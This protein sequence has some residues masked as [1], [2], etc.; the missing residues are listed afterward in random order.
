MC[1]VSMTP[2]VKSSRCSVIERNDTMVRPV[3]PTESANQLT[4]HSS[5]NTANVRPPATIWCLVRLEI[6][7]PTERK[8]PPRRNR[9]T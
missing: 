1:F 2:F 3:G 6:S 4:I 8:Q 9:P 5:R 7:S